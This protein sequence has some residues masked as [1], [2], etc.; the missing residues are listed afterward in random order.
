VL[1]GVSGDGPASFGSDVA[2]ALTGT[3][4]GVDVLLVVEFGL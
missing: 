1:A 3:N 4:S 2:G